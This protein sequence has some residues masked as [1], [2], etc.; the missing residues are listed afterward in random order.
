MAY[1]SEQQKRYESQLEKWETERNA[2]K[3]LMVNKKSDPYTYYHNQNLE[4]QLEELQNPMRQ[5]QPPYQ[6]QYYQ[7]PAKASYDNQAF[8]FEPDESVNKAATEMGNIQYD[9]K[10]HKNL[11]PYS[12]RKS[13][14]DILSA[15][16]SSLNK[17]KQTYLTDDHQ[18]VPQKTYLIDDLK[19]IP[20]TTYLTDDLQCI[21]QKTYLTDDPVQQQ[22]Y[23]GSHAKRPERSPTHTATWE[24]GAVNLNSANKQQQQRDTSAVTSN[25]LSGG[26]LSPYQQQLNAILYK[27]QY[28]SQS[29]PTSPV[30]SSKVP[31]YDTRSQ[32]SANLNLFR[33]IT[34]S[35]RKEQGDKRQPAVIRHTTISKEILKKRRSNIQ[36]ELTELEKHFEELGLDSEDD[37]TIPK[38]SNSPKPINYHLQRTIVRE[39]HEP[40]PESLEVA[41]YNWD[42]RMQQR[43][44]PQV[45]NN[46]TEKQVTEAY[47]TQHQ[48]HHTRQDIQKL[49][50]APQRRNSPNKHFNKPYQQHTKPGT[51]RPLHQQNDKCT[52][53]SH[54][55][56]QPGLQYGAQGCKVKQQPKLIIRPRSASM[57]RP[58]NGD[59]SKSEPSSP[60]KHRRPSLPGRKTYA[61][62]ITQMVNV[63]STSTLRPSNSE[64]NLTDRSVFSSS[65]SVTGEPITVDANDAT[66]SKVKSRKQQTPRIV[67]HRSEQK[68]KTKPSTSGSE[69]EGYSSSGVESSLYSDHHTLKPHDLSSGSSG[70]DSQSSGECL[71]VSQKGNYKETMDHLISLPERES[72]TSRSAPNLYEQPHKQTAVVQKHMPD[73]RNIHYQQQPPP[74]SRPTKHSIQVTPSPPPPSSPDKPLPN[75]TVTVQTR[76][77][78]MRAT[79][80]A[81]RP[82][83]KQ[84]ANS[85]TLEL[86][87][88]VPLHST[89]PSKIPQASSAS[90]YAPLRAPTATPRYSYNSDTSFWDST[91]QSYSV[92][93]SPENYTPPCD[94]PRIHNTDDQLPEITKAVAKV[95]P[96]VAGDR[97]RTRKTTLRYYN[98]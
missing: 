95:E 67:K 50:N 20:Q 59:G 4:Q 51:I 21:P 42:E 52:P 77:S 35:S 9:H 8:E 11:D 40:S 73:T 18:Y 15:S 37:S 6:D 74:P 53:E 27:D 5:Q 22:N 85:R 80:P 39:R 13:A 61:Q 65:Y 79:Q 34:N 45:L 91:D 25:E 48:P 36:D 92:V 78:P 32:Q 47:I 3:Q 75:V 10:A 97:P 16:S 28:R 1:C 17:P 81:A 62:G 58:Q 72:F 86:V 7:A 24:Q 93:L 57:E 84:L 49:G 14:D 88:P 70:L 55:L 94:S 38:T 33:P 60:L 63:F 56:T 44:S 83:K 68:N 41:Q 29:Q 82:I 98:S 26:T 46:Q 64:P 76:Q 90:P 71:S 43:K 87:D 69:S 54:Y 12:G 2:W 66:K 89:Q 30:R 23:S 96:T 31:Q 19:N